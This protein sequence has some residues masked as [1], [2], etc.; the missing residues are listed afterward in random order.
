MGSRYPVGRR[1]ATGACPTGATPVG[2][3]FEQYLRA[4]TPAFVREARDFRARSSPC[5]G[6][7]QSGV[8]NREAMS[9]FSES[10]MR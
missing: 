4:I 2:G 6:Q 7:G 8:S 3:Q 1:G 5:E 9:F 10:Q